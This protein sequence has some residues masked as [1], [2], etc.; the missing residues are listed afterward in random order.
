MTIFV[1]LDINPAARK[2]VGCQAGRAD[3]APLLLVQLLCFGPH[4][5]T[6]ALPLSLRMPTSL[7]S[8]LPY[9]SRSA[10]GRL[11]NTGIFSR[12]KSRTSPHHAHDRRHIH[13]AG[14]ASGRTL[15]ESYDSRESKATGVC[16]SSRDRLHAAL[17]ARP[18]I[19]FLTRRNSTPL[20]STRSDSPSLKPYGI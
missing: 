18:R 2:P 15:A 17:R 6:K 20:S 5:E 10:C 19:S 4:T 14:R 1:C 16:P 13:G 3:G 12:T 8:S 11:M 9:V 7:S